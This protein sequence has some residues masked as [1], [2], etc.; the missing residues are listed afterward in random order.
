LGP[1]RQRASRARRGLLLLLLLLLL[2]LLARL[3]GQQ[4]DNLQELQPPLDP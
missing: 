2:P 3:A 1:P 4:P